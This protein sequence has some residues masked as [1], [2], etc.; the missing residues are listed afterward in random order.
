MHIHLVFN[1]KI[2]LSLLIG[3]NYTDTNIN[4]DLLNNY[5][6][7]RRFS[8]ARRRIEVSAIR[9]SK[10]VQ[11]TTVPS[12]EGLWNLKKKKNAFELNRITRIHIK[13]KI[14]AIINVKGQT[15]LV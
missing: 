4:F 5:L 14:S 12:K 13:S 6:P 9:Q 7:G 3:I 8:I 2:D 1:R 15:I 11:Q 10:N